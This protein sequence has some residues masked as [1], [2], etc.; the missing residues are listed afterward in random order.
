MR[1]KRLFLWL[2]PVFVLLAAGAA[3]SRAPKVDLS[4]PEGVAEQF[5]KGQAEGDKR[6]VGAL[7]TPALK[8]KFQKDKTLYVVERAKLQKPRLDTKAMQKTYDTPEAKAYQLDYR[9]KAQNREKPLPM[10]EA[11]LVKKQGSN[12]LIEEYSPDP[13]V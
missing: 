4:T 7:L 9:I 12:W 6:L 13:K 1:K 11:V 10:K 3:C 2:I 5:I 8:A